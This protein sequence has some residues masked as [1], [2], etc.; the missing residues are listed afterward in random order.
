MAFAQTSRTYDADHERR[1]LFTAANNVPE[2]ATF[3]FN[4]ARDILSLA[5]HMLEGHI[6]LARVSIPAAVEHFRQAA[7]IEDGLRYDEPPDWYIPARESLGRTYMIGNQYEDAEKVFREELAHHPHSPRAL[8]GLSQCLKAEGKKADAKQTE[9]DFRA[10][11][12]NADVKL[13]IDDL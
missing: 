10:A 1:S 12:K 2:D 4:R 13:T 11:W 6:S 5:A 3:G 7:Q 8:F 9:L